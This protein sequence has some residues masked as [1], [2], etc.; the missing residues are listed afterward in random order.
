MNHKRIILIF[1]GIIFVIFGLLAYFNAFYYENHYLIFWF[2]YLA[3]LVIGIGLIFSEPRLILSQLY[4]VFIPDIIWGIDFISYLINGKSLMGI[5]DYFFL[6]GPIPLKIVTM[7]HLLV[8][9][10]CLVALVYIRDIKNKFPILLISLLEL[11]LFYYLA[12]TFTPEIYNINC[13]YKPCG[14]LQIS[15]Y[16]PII[17]FAGVFLMI[18]LSY[19][20]VN[21][22]LRDKTDK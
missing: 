16:Y 14:N 22:F 19:F 2:C 12:I 21:R 17:W 13:V 18:S 9:P 6:E 1:I 10:V 7:Q 20:L 11:S 4:I 3:L 5:V 8:I 15:G